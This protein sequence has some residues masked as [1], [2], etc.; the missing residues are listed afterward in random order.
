MAQYN[1]PP[2][3]NVRGPSAEDGP[4]PK[5]ASELGDTLGAFRHAF[6]ISDPSL[7]DCPIEYA[8]DGFCALTGYT[9]EEIVNRNCRFL[10][11]PATDQKQIQ[12]IRDAVKDKT[13]YTGRILNYKKDGKPFWNQLTISPVHMDGKPKFLG[14]Q[15]DV[16]Q[17]TVGEKSSQVQ[18]GDIPLLIRYEAR[19][20]QKVATPAE[21]LAAK[22]ERLNKGNVDNL[23]KVT[24]N[25]RKPAQQLFRPF[26]KNKPS[27]TTPTSATTSPSDKRGTEGQDSNLAG[28]RVR[29]RRVAFDLAT[30]L[31]RVQKNFVITNPHLPD[32]PIVFCS[33]PFLELSGYTREEIIGRNCRFLQGPLT[34]RR[35]VLKIKAAIDAREECTVQLLNYRKNGT[36][37]W[38]MFHL[39]PVFSAQTGEIHFFVGVQTDVTHQEKLPDASCMTPPQPSTSDHMQE[40]TAK[41]AVAGADRVT[42]DVNKL[43]AA[44]VGASFAGKQATRIWA[45]HVRPITA[46]RPHTSTSWHWQ[47]LQKVVGKNRL[48][49][50]HLKPVRQLGKG[51]AGS[52]LLVELAGTGAL[53][54][55]KVLNKRSMIER[56]KVQRAFTEREI[57]ATVD[58]HFLPTLFDVFQTDQH[59]CFITEY[60]AG[61]E[62]YSML[63]GLPG[64]RVPE[65]HAQFY[66]AEVLLSLEYLHMMGI[67]YRDLKPE[68]IMIRADGHLVLTDF[69]L[70]FRTQ[71]KPEVVMVERENGK[72]QLWPHFVAEPRTKTHSF[73]GTAEY[74]APEVI[75]N[76]G[77]S[78][79]VDWWSLGILLYELLYGVSPFY[80]STRAETFENILRARLEFPSKPQVSSEAKSLVRSLLIRDPEERLGSQF[81]ATE[82][83]AHPFFKHTKWALLRTMTP[84]V[85]PLKDE[86]AMAPASEGDAFKYAY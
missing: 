2:P 18:S 77:H 75:N 45:P 64:N 74:L 56:N 59:I 48:T 27:P 50:Q 38:N 36:M 21:E 20:Q 22:L 10:Q 19:L 3:S 68:N 62:L 80:G 53:F 32:H 52:V 25:D 39:A 8:S 40:Q 44:W 13:T 15:V 1:L 16:T 49:P 70:A 69:D 37:F 81:G 34:D 65:I 55:M 73:V 29:V 14:V 24:A 83:K 51:D 85:T 4:L 33:D 11:G 82:I 17:Y 60:C 61:G 66:V 72:P 63:S 28:Y 57:L 84:P 47:M 46:C 58:H 43:Q 5:V 35:A 30:S 6:V 12:A 86:V 71:C 42:E 54:A 78:A 76:T 31:E 67:I 41:I 26:G 23:G 9:S 79:A 7:P